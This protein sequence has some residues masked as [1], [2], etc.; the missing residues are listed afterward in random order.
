[1]PL[2]FINVAA[3]KV[4]GFRLCACRN[5][6]DSPE[7]NMRA[8]CLEMPQAPPRLLNKWR[9]VGRVGRVSGDVV[10]STATEAVME[11]R[12]CGVQRLR[13]TAIAE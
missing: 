5:G 2:D 3:A 8:G 6:A 7:M 10:A 12:D 13:S 1:M 11:Y 9:S 4:G